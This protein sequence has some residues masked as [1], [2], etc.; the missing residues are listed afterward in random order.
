MSTTHEPPATL[1]TQFGR[2]QDQFSALVA[3][4]GPNQWHA[5]TPCTEWDV[6]A[7]V[8]HL[9]GEQVWAVPLVAG[10]TLEE[11]GTQF[12][13]DLLGEDP[14]A[15]WR[16]SAA[17][18]RAAFEQP[19]ALSGSVHTSMGPQPT[20]D[21]L[22][23]MTADLIAHRWDLGK[24]IGQPQTFTDEELTQLEQAQE[25]FAPMQKELEAAGIFAAPK[26]TTPQS[27]RR[28]R[29]LAAFGRSD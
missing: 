8:N 9:V 28:T 17:E 12:D 11:V 2:A 1:R 7:L 16:E 23:D 3:A 6:R 29:V 15:K 21:Y 26:P 13:G 18:S 20:V 25:R 24:A 10:K 19:D 22:G 4:I 14:G 5:P 27:D